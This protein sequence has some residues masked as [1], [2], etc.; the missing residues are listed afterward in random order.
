M[1]FVGSRMSS[2]PLPPRSATSGQS[3]GE[4]QEEHS[5]GHASSPPAPPPPLGPL[6]CWATQGLCELA[7]AEREL[8]LLRERQAGEAEGVARG[9]ERAL[10]G[11]RREE[12]RLLERVEQDHRD[13]QCRLEQLQRENAAAVRVG[14]SLVDQRL[15]EVGQLREQIQGWGGGAGGGAGAG[16]GGEAERDQLQRAIAELTQ[17]WE[18]TLSLKRVNFRPSPQP[19]PIAFGEIRVQEHN[20]TFPVATCCGPQGRHCS[21]HSLEGRG[22]EGRNTPDGAGPTHGQAVEEGGGGSGSGRVV[23]KLRLSSGLEEESGGEGQ[24]ERLKLLSPRWRRWPP[25]KRDG[26]DRESSQEE[27]ELESLG[28]DT[29]GEELF[30]AIP[31]YL[32]NG[33]SEGEEPREGEESGEGPLRG[34]RNHRNLSLRQSRRISAPPGGGRTE[35]DSQ[36]S[37]Q[38]GVRGVS[39]YN[40][41]ALASPKTSP[42]EPMSSLSPRA[43]PIPRTRLSLSSS[44]DAPLDLGRAPSPADSLDS[45]YTF[46]VSSPRDSGGSLVRETRLTRST[47]DLSCRTP[48]LIDG[49]GRDRQGSWWVNH[50][51]LGSSP[52]I[53]GRGQGARGDGGGQV[54]RSLSLSVIEVP[55]AGAAKP[56]PARE[57]GGGRAASALMEEEEEEGSPGRAGRL[58]RRF[59]KQGSGRA[60]LTLPSGVHATPQGQLFV[61]DSGNARL[62][63][64]D[65]RGNVLQQ[66]SSPGPEGSGRRC[67]NYF[68]VA[69]N[70][71]GLIALSCAAE[72]ALLVF[73]RHG[74]ALRT[75][76]ARD[77]LDAPRGVA[78]DGLDR[79]LVADL[80]RGTLA[81][82]KLDPKTGARLESTV[83]PG[84]HRPYLVAA[85]PASG[86]VAVSERGGES[87]RGPCVRVLEPGWTTVR[88][89]GVCSGLGPL[90]SCPWG[91]CIDH[92]G[93]VLVAD[94]AEEHRVLV[95]PARGVGRPL[96]TQGLSSPRGLALLP[97]G[98]LVVSDS[99]HHCIKIFQYK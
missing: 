59:G 31:A 94:W 55:N 28:S 20:L 56:R 32:S 50:G 39:R 92:D 70:G 13:T 37:N 54:C 4:P 66:V 15:R 63:V 40:H 93:D 62:Q 71:K 24:G 12:R 97:E 65:A 75:L 33:D 83:V 60:D 46:I 91:V 85:C 42:R 69:V 84:F 98:H 53:S 57:G 89:L 30:Q 17:P 72:R 41:E 25:P 73:N 47:A 48:P 45:C 34:Q 26:S 23:R 61:V 88:V 95:Y 64:T 52:S 86:L 27:E 87:G 79:F 78:V 38:G 82:L 7:R 29:K 36:R 11:A 74:R 77:E 35:Q 96:V 80:R 43:R 81:V 90:L 44:D 22:Q 6:P 51:R 3:D 5:H 18:I 16:A 8:R 67:R 68:D 58:L 14:Q 1:M 49:G 99:M 19:K 10:L 76:G 21:L 2:C 9:V